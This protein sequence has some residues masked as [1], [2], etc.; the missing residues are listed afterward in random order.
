MVDLHC[1]ILPDMDDGARDSREA[2]AMAQ[3][4][5]ERGTT[6]LV[7]TPHCQSGGSEQVL[8][9]T[10]YLRQQLQ[11]L[12]LPLKLYA[13]MEIFAT[14]ATARLLQEGKLLTLNGSRYP[15]VEFDF[16]GDEQRPGKL[17]AQLTEA[18]YRPVVAHPERYSYI[19]QNPRLLNDWVDMGCLLQLNKG[20]FAGHFGPVCQELAF[21]LVARG[22]AGAV[23]SDAHGFRR[24]SPRLE[25]LWD[26]LSHNFSPRAAQVLL[27]TNPMKILRDEPINTPRLDRF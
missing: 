8:A 15:L 7:A 5:L 26:I 19:Q 27:Q 13:G 4:A 21:G 20:S 25:Q 6:R 23:A 14:E 9:A 2:I 16:E 10:E 1:H 24:R 11:C 22:Y 18:G 12:Q 17:L 3:L